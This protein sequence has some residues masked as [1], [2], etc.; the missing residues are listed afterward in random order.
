M[1]SVHTYAYDIY[2]FFFYPHYKSISIKIISQIVGKFNLHLKFKLGTSL[3]L[4][5][6]DKTLLMKLNHILLIKLT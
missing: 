2:I 5:P 4:I 3:E 6:F 1:L